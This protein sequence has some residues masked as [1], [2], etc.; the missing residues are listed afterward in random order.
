MKF[1]VHRAAFLQ[2]LNTAQTAISGKTTLEIL[3]GVKLNLSADALTITGS[4]S[5]ISIETIL[6]IADEDAQLT[7]EEPGSVVL[8]ARFFGEIVKRLP[9]DTFTLTVNDRFQ[10][11]I[12]SVPLNLLLTVLSRRLIR[13]CR[14]STWA[15][16]SK[17]LAIC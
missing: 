11:T 5:D 7:I 16:S 2:Y 8:P 12:V 15:I 1:S 14:K 13:I 9:E 3:T 17:F 6:S 4:N 10:T